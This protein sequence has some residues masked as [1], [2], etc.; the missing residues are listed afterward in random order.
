MN[1]LDEA[2]KFKKDLN[3]LKES[4]GENSL[5]N[6][7]IHIS[8]ISSNSKGDLKHLKLEKSNFNWKDLLK[9]LKEYNCKGYVISNSPNLEEDAK[10]LKDHYMA[11]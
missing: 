9:A 2:H 8:G 10:M 7:H 1:S 5:D 11:I 6:M 3:K 4:L